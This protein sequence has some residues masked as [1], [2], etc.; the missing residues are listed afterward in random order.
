MTCSH[1]RCCSRVF[2]SRS[3]WGGLFAYAYFLGRLNLVLRRPRVHR[4]LDGVT[5]AVLVGLGGRLAWDRS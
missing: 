1:A 2:T 3:D 5:G 4:C